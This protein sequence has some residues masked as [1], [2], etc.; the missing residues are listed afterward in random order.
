MQTLLYFFTH[1]NHCVDFLS[2]RSH[3]VCWCQV[4]TLRRIF[5]LLPA[6]TDSMISLRLP[7]LQRSSRRKKR[8]E[9]HTSN[10]TKFRPVNSHT[11]GILLVWCMYAC[12]SFRHWSGKCRFRNKRR[13]SKIRALLLY[14]RRLLQSHQKHTKF[15]W[16]LHTKQS[17]ASGHSVVYAAIRCVRCE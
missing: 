3:A 5:L 2:T 4:A 6:P 7:Y 1:S 13:R 10:L 16:I 9:K 15:T 17:Q 11:N 12:V 8:R 14:V